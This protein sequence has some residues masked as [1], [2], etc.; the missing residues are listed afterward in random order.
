MEKERALQ[1]GG[2]EVKSEN[3]PKTNLGVKNEKKK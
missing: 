1:G 2:G 3:E